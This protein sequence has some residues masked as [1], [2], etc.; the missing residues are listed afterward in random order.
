MKIVIITDGNNKLGMGHVYQSVSLAHLIIQKNHAAEIIFITQSNDKV[1][2]LLKKTNCAVYRY[3]DN[4]GIFNALKKAKPDRV[5]F[6]KLNVS[7][8]LAQKIKEQLRTKLII[9]T[10]LTKANQYADVTV[11]AGMGSDFKNIHTTEKVTGKIEFWGPKYWVLRPEF[12]KYEKKKKHFSKKI[13]KV[14]LMFGGADPS[15]LSSTVLNELLQMNYSFHITLVLGTAFAN[16]DELNTVIRN[17][18]STQSKVKI[19]EELTT[20]AATMHRSDVVLVSPGLS[21]F[22][23]LKVG[24]PVLCFHQNRFQREAWKGHIPTIDKSKINTLP[25][26]IENRLFIFPNDAFIVS[27]EAGKGVNEIINAIR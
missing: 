12:Y 2:G 7:P 8:S 1:V 3:P 24:T 19:L 9:F 10:N 5:I 22:E 15:N 6:D 14:M 13:K 23:A 4:K 27:M 16:R 26:L 25:S 21:F 18:Y 17:N 11:M 20:V